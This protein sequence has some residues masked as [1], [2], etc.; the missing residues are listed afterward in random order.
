M[1]CDY[2]TIFA[3]KPNITTIQNNLM[4]SLDAIHFMLAVIIRPFTKV[5][6]PP[7]A[8]PPHA[9]TPITSLHRPPCCGVYDAAPQQ[10]F[11][12]TP[13]PQLITSP[14]RPPCCGA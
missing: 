10:Q 13:R 1:I 9:T 3:T 14:H 7:T 11:L 4:Q 2:D 6:N 8:V 5:C 12:R